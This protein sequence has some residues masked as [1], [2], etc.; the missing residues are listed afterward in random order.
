MGDLDNTDRELLH[1][2]KEAQGIVTMAHTTC[3]SKQH[4]AGWVG[5]RLAQKHPTTEGMK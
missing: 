4:L 1:S 5:Y 2:L 3:G